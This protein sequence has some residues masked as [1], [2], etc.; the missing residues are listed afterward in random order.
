MKLLDLPPN[1]CENVSIDFMA[2]TWYEFD[3]AC[4]WLIKNGVRLR[5]FD[6]ESGT[7]IGVQIRK[8]HAYW[9]G[10]MLNVTH[11]DLGLH[12]SGEEGGVDYTVSAPRFIRT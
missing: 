5:K 2:D 12:V 1:L 6:F 11:T 9:Q 7:Y 3:Q 10:K 4:A 8:G